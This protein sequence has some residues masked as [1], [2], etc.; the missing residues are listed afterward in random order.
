MNPL[1]QVAVGHHGDFDQDGAAASVTP[2]TVDER[3][4]WQQRDDWLAVV[5]LSGAARRQ[6]GRSSRRRQDSGQ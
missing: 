4:V 2:E 3:S 6:G 1:S 5:G